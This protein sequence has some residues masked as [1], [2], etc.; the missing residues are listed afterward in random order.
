MQN[1]KKL[2]NDLDYDG[3]GF[4][5]QEKILA[6]LKRKTTFALKCIVMKIS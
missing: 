5:E 2:V 4:L 3:I 1:D 6:R